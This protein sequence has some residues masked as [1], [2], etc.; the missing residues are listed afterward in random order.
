[1]L[2]KEPELGRSVQMGAKR[3]LWDF[4]PL[5]QP[6]GGRDYLGFFPEPERLLPVA[7]QLGGAGSLGSCAALSPLLLKRGRIRLYTGLLS[8]GPVDT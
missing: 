4:T 3:A 6:P 7:L 1:M 8:R 5:Q 2:Q